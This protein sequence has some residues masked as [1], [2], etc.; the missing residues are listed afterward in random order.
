MTEHMPNLT[1]PKGVTVSR[2]ALLC[3][4]QL[5]LND[6]KSLGRTLQQFECSIQ[7]WLGDWWCYGQHRYG[8]RKA[9]LTLKDT[10]PSENDSPFYRRA[11][12]TLMNYG[13]VAGRVAS[14]RRREVLSFS[15]H[16]V[17]APL[18]PDE[19]DH[20]LDIAVRDRLSVRKLELE[21][22]KREVSKPDHGDRY[23][24]WCLTKQAERSTRCILPPWETP[25]FERF[26]V[27]NAY[28]SDVH[29]F[30][31]EVKAAHEFWS[32]MRALLRRVRERATRAEREQA[33]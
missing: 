5:T 19:Q 1:L 33:A 14:S 8:E 32:N 23:L 27:I 21:I 26:L 25:D 6:W 29:E 4:E 13:S 3:P 28:H 18:E 9:K 11:Y 7:W 31:K 12:G 2:T 16:V 22:F 30:A 17:I 20:W 15:H 10:L 24:L